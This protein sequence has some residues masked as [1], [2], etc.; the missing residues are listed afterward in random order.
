MAL[1]HVR[2]PLEVCNTVSMAADSATILQMLRLNHLM[3]RQSQKKARQAVRTNG[4]CLVLLCFGRIVVMHI[5]SGIMSRLDRYARVAHRHY[6][7][8]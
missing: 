2:K 3:T 5:V 4:G 7:A 8:T 1:F 6:R